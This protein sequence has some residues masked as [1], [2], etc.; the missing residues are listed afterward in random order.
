[1]ARADTE[2]DFAAV[3]VGRCVAGTLGVPALV[4]K[5]RDSCEF[6]CLFALREAIPFQARIVPWTE[7]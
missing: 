7:S 4:A 6:A 3:L 2:D 1:M 5:Q